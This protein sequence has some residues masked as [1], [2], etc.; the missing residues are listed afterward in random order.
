MRSLKKIG[1]GI[2]LILHLGHF[3]GMIWGAN[4]ADSRAKRITNQPEFHRSVFIANSG[5]RPNWSKDAFKSSRCLIILAR[6]GSYNSLTNIIATANET[7]VKSK[8][9]I[10]VTDSGVVV[11]DPEIQNSVVLVLEQGILNIK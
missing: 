4:S 9:V 6:V 5:Q 1:R 3:Q 10:L 7:A 8:M 11:T 2:G